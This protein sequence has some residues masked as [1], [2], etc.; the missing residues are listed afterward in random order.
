[1]RTRVIM[2]VWEVAVGIIA[3]VGSCNPKESISLP[4]GVAKAEGNVVYFL[5]IKAIGPAGGTIISADGKAILQIP[6]GALDATTQISISPIS[7]TAPLGVS[8]GY[9]LLPRGL[10]LLKPAVLTIKYEAEEI[11]G[12]APEALGMAFQNPSGVWQAQG[13]VVLDKT[14]ISLS[15][16]VSQLGDWAAFQM[17]SIL[18]NKLALLPNKTVELQAWQLPGKDLMA[19]LHPGTS[20][21]LDEP[22]VMEPNATSGWSVNGDKT[23]ST[24][25]NGTFSHTKE[26][27]SFTA[28]AEA[29]VPNPVSIGTDARL[30]NMPVQLITQITVRG[31]T[32]ITLNGG[33]FATQKLLFPYCFG[34]I[35]SSGGMTVISA[36]NDTT[37]MQLFYPWYNPGAYPFQGQGGICGVSL[38]L[39][40]NSTRSESFLRSS[41]LTQNGNI[42]VPASGTMRVSSYGE[43][44]GLITGTFT[45]KVWYLDAT[46]KAI[47]VDITG[48]FMSR[49]IL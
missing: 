47:V 4:K 43:I 49:R 35:T 16:P 30:S 15:V 17:A 44:G 22:V 45:G 36:A 33:P 25:T 10:Q 26:S 19:T 13:G 41:S 38:N 27:I 11:D 12:S 24:G 29:P 3:L 1:M 46:G 5:A 14:T 40:K 8:N 21:P 31:V 23:Y 34:E 18:P 48:Q 7:N 42:S 28:P 39:N 37:E 9:R 20:V 2:S 32:Y 6:A